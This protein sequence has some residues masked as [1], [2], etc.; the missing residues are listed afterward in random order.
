VLVAR[1]LL[2]ALESEGR[3]DGLLDLLGV[4]HL[5]SVCRLVGLPR[6]NYRLVNFLLVSG[7]I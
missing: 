3:E 6:V 7:Y 5:E 2:R 1:D 4:G